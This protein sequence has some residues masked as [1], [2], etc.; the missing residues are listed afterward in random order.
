MAPPE[1]RPAQDAPG[2][3]PARRHVT[4]VTPFHASRWGAIWG[5]IFGRH[6]ATPGDSEPHHNAAEL[7]FSHVEPH[8]ATVRFSFASRGSG[9]QIPMLLAGQFRLHRLLHLLDVRLSDL[10]AAVEGGNAVGFSA[11]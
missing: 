7:L 9:V 10:E 3:W 2:T 11:L 8:R 4:E 5:A 6:R 1:S